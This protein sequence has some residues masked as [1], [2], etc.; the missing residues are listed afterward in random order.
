MDPYEDYYEGTYEDYLKE[1]AREKKAEPRTEPGT[2]PGTVAGDGSEA[3]PEAPPEAPQIDSATIDR[4]FE[5]GPDADPLDKKETALDILRKRLA[6]SK[7]EKVDKKK[8]KEE[9]DALL[10][11]IENDRVSEGLM[12]M[13]VGAKIAEKGVAAGL[14]E[15][16]PQAM[17][18]FNKQHAQKQAREREVAT[19]TITEGFSREREQ[20]V[21]DRALEMAVFESDLRI[22][23][24]KEEERYKAIFDTEPYVVI[25]NSTHSIDGKDVRVP[26]GTPLSLNS[27]QINQLG[28]LGI[29]VIPLE[30]YDEDMMAYLIGGDKDLTA[31]GIVA[32]L[33]G[34][35]RNYLYSD[36]ENITAFAN[37]GS[38]YNFSIMR[39]KAALIL[40]PI[41]RAEY[42]DTP[43]ISSAELLGLRRAYKTAIQDGKHLYDDIGGLINLSRLTPAEGG[44][45]MSGLPRIKGELLEALR[46][47]KIPGIDTWADDLIGGPIDPVTG[48][49][50]DITQL[51]EFQVRSRLILAKIA[52]ILLG[53]S[54]RTI[55]NEDRERVAQALGF[56]VS[57]PGGKMTLTAPRESYFKDERVI[58]LALEVTRDVLVRNMN[59]VGNEFHSHLQMLGLNPERQA[60]QGYDVPT[61]RQEEIVSTLFAD[62]TT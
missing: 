17:E 4:L 6:E 14:S 9:I 55:S 20:R 36:P 47:S 39:P 8:L 43:K 22:E 25:N 56:D 15:S 5:S 3:P 45:A 50:R 12:A 54:G 27:D 38:K 58:R 52:P 16:L 23:Q 34:K 62:L 1:S 7:G 31:E 11:A 33:S 57:Y 35:E 24:F 19:A 13:I 51:S 59:Q 42:G 28:D 61:K 53:E 49:K 18:F 26:F 21:N 60:V 48:K 41:L 10:P 2:E 46:A 37:F 44:G 32:R 40:D 30:N 29:Q